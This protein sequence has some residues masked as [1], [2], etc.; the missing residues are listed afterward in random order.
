MSGRCDLLALG[1]R[2]PPA[3]PVIDNGQATKHV[4]SML[5]GVRSLPASKLHESGGP[6]LALESQA[7]AGFV[8]GWTIYRLHQLFALPN[9]FLGHHEGDHVF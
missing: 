3:A 9:R 2:A 1:K 6:W 7:C 4:F 8:A 5:L